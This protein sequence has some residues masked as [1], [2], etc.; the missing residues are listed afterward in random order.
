MFKPKVSVII[1][2]YNAEKYI[3]QCAHSLFAQTLDN[4]EYIFV[5]DCS[6]DNSID[7]VKSILSQYPNR[8][9][10]VKLLHNTMN[11]GV[12]Y[13]RQRGIEAAE[14]EF[15]IH[16]DPDDWI[17]HSMYAKM[18][19]QATKS[20]SEIVVCDYYLESQEHSKVHSDCIPTLKHELFKSLITHQTSGYL[21]NK[22]VQRDYWNSLDLKI[23]DGLSLWEDFSITVPLL[24]LA[25]R[26]SKLTIP[27]YHYRQFSSRLS[28]TSH[29]N[30]KKIKSCM[31]AIDYIQDTLRDEHN[32][33]FY[34]EG[35]LSLRLNTSKGLL[36]QPLL[37]NPTLWRT[38]NNA[39]L[40]QIIISP[41][42]W[43]TKFV[44]ILGKL[45]FDTI[46]KGIARLNSRIK[47]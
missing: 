37:F 29:I 27:L 10:H 38:F 41:V 7:V 9:S 44:S 46:L 4:I 43:S 11:K 17:E 25:T 36:T 31:M 45:K 14:G 35:Y 39:K 28:I 40:R 15:L 5:D 20:S 13:S 23:K 16:C 12:G 21:W 42:S 18:Y 3:E 34:H 6:P 8:I 30:Q 1:P 22:L 24:I 26:I 47:S 2:V 32:T 33:H 19:E